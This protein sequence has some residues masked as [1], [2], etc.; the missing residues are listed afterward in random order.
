MRSKGLAS[1]VNKKYLDGT[2]PVEV[3]FEINGGDHTHL[4]IKYGDGK[5]EF[6]YYPNGGNPLIVTKTHSYKELGWYTINIVAANDVGFVQT[7]KIGNIGEGNQK[8]FSV[9]GQHH[10]PG[11]VC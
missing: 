11:C 4:H 7:S 1:R 6:L 5:E 3:T 8:C 10:K 2:E 9:C